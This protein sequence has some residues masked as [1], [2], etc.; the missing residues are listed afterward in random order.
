MRC[1]KGAAP[2]RETFYVSEDLPDLPSLDVVRQ[3]YGLEYD[4]SK[5]CNQSFNVAKKF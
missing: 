3:A 5:P 1:I 2:V 4:V